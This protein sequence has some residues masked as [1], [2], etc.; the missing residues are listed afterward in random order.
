MKPFN[1]VLIIAMVSTIGIGI[2]LGVV[3]LAM[4]GSPN[5][6]GTWDSNGLHFTSTKH[7]NEKVSIVEENMEEFKSIYIDNAFGS[8]TFKESSAFGIGITTYKDRGELDW[9]LVN[10]ELVIAQKSSVNQNLLNFDFMSFGR[11]FEPSVTVYL[12]K[13][14]KMGNVTVKSDS[15]RIDASNFAADTVMFEADF[16][17]VI[18]NNISAGTL[19]TNLSSGVFEG[20]NLNVTGLFEFESD[21][22][23]SS[24]T[25]VT[26]DKLVAFASSGEIR[27]DNCAINT[28]DADSGFG[29]ITGDNVRVKDMILNCESGTID[30]NGDIGATKISSSFGS[31]NVRTSHSIDEF[32]LSLKTDFGKIKVDG[33]NRGESYNYGNSSGKIFDIEGD[34][35]DIDVF[36]SK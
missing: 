35:G 12:P 29:K 6:S 2:V 4:G 7:S 30:M 27:F 3:G 33:Q 9:S 31:V 13:D 10:G 21:F 16:G 17:K 20:S 28:I 24:F 15:G 5:L 26:A 34:S 18:L 32:I 14:H 23:E 1:K 19:D 36:F 22:G 11:V 25:N 8:V